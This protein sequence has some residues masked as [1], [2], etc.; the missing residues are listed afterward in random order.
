MRRTSCCL[1]W[2]YNWKYLKPAFMTDCGVLQM[3]GNARGLGSVWIIHGTQNELK[4]MKSLHFHFC[5]A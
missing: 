1:Q 2:D 3:S 4:R 5:Q